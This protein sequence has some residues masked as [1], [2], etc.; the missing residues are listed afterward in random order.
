[1]VMKGAPALSKT[2]SPTT[3]ATLN[4]KRAASGHGTASRPVVACT[5]KLGFIDAVRVAEA[6]SAWQWRRIVS[7][8]R[9]ISRDKCGPYLTARRANSRRPRLPTRRPW[10]AAGS[11]GRRAANRPANFEQ[12]MRHHALA[13]RS[14]IYVSGNVEV[15]VSGKRKTRPL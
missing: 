4:T 2:Y 8:N 13:M 10:R 14:R 12:E 11:A 3:V 7:E 9:L 1:M 15:E 5:S 6:G